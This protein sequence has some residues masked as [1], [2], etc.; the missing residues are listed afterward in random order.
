MKPDF[1][2]L[3]INRIHRNEKAELF[4]KIGGLPVNKLTEDEM[5]ELEKVQGFE[6][7]IVNDEYAKK[8]K[9]KA[10]ESVYIEKNID[11][12]LF[13]NSCWELQRVNQFKGGNLILDEVYRFRHVGTGKFLAVAENRKDLTLINT[14][15]S[16][17]TLFCFKSE[18]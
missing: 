9:D 15:N 16:L 14:T 17:D 13:T 2:Q 11:R 8:L 7:A 12:L 18:M 10:T 6:W 5:L 1:L 4:R 3:Q